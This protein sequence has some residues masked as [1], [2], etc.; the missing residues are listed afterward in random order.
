MIKIEKFVIN[1]HNVTHLAKAG[2]TVK[3]HFTSGEHIF[4]KGTLEEVQKTMEMHG[5]TWI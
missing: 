3:V 2:D 1:A 5:D 4:V